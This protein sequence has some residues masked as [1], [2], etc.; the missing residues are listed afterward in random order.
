MRIRWF[1]NL[2][3][4]LDINPSNLFMSNQLV[5]YN[6]KI[7]VPTQNNLY[8]LDVIT[9]STIF[10]HK[11]TS[12]Y[13]PLIFK[14]ILYTIDNNFLIASDINT[15]KII[16]S[17]N[18]NQKISDYLNIKRKSVDIKN[19]MFADNKIFVF[20]KNSYLIQFAVSGEIHEVYKMPKKFTRT[21]YL[22]R[23][24]LSL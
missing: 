21:Q 10:K 2:N 14:N 18:I 22:S 20:L 11:F 24:K 19:F 5:V 17:Y 15:G 9:G 3:K 6:N 1:I 12:K 16:F 8:I 4:S 7:F 23:T 13:R